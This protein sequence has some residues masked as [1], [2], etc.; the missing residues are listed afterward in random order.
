MAFIFAVTFL[1]YPKTGM[2]SSRFLVFHANSP[3][4]ITHTPSI[5]PKLLRKMR[6]NS[7]AFE[8]NP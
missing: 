6:S 2:K 3:H 8:K 7:H 5:L 4:D 1:S